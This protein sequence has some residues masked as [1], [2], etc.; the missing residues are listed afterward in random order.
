MELPVS[1]INGRFKVTDRPY[2]DPGKCTVCGSVSKPV[3][4]FDMT[5]DYYGAILLCSDC[6]REAFILMGALHPESV[7]PAQ[8]IPLFDQSNKT[9]TDMVHEYLAASLESTRRLIAILPDAALLD[10]YAEVVLDGD[11]DDAGGETGRDEDDSQLTLFQGPNDLPT[12][13]GRTTRSVF[14]D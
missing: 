8:V 12:I 7:E 2:A 1:V 14:D 13:T 10:E 5:V 3:V 4:D 6:I 11:S 9:D